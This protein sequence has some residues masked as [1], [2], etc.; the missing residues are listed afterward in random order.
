MSKG[1]KRRPLSVSQQQFADNWDR[2]FRKDD[3]P[4]GPQGLPD[5]QKGDRGPRS[6]EHQIDFSKYWDAPKSELIREV[7]YDDMWRHSCTATMETFLIGKGE[8]CPYCG[9]YNEIL[10]KWQPERL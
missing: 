9:E 10:K 8:E 6:E 1:S 7:N 4:H 3:P 5:V 2:A